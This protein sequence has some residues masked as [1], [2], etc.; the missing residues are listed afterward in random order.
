METL[1]GG[2]VAVVTQSNM[3]LK[4]RNCKIIENQDTGLS[5]DEALLSIE[6]PPNSDMGDFTFPCFRLAKTMRKAP[7]MIAADLS[8]S[9]KFELFKEVRALGPY[10][11]FL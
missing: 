11:N 9:I 3:N 7:Q 6:T 8:K 5:F 4:E 1:E 10:V 2:L